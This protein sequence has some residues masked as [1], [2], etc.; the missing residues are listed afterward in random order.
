MPLTLN[1]DIEEQLQAI[2]RWEPQV[3]ALI[4][5]DEHAA[6]RRAAEAGAGPLSGWSVAVK[7]IIDWKGTPT[8]C[9]AD[10]M[11]DE[12]ARTSAAIIV[13]LEQLGAFVMSKAVTTVFAFF[14]PGPTRNPWNLE[15][16][17]GG[18][19]S[20]P[21]AAVACGMVRLALGSQTVGSINRPASFCG[22]VGFKPTYGRIPMGGVF[23]IAPA[24]DTLGWFTA[25]VGDAQAAFAALTGEEAAPTPRSLRIGVVED[26]LCETADV[27]MLAAVRA[28]A[29]RLRRAGYDV[30]AV[31]LPPSAA[32]I[33]EAHWT[34][35]A[36][37]CARSHDSLFARHADRYTPKLRDLILRGQQIDDAQ[38]SA[39]ES[40]RLGAADDL[41]RLFDDH[42]VL[43]TP[44]APGPAPHGIAATGDP[45]MNLVWTYTGL[46]SLTLAAELSEN[47]LPLGMQFVAPRMVDDM[48][49]A[50]G[51]VLERDLG[52]NARP[53]LPE[54]M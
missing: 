50:A 21:A 49:L 9:G 41:E 7:D 37:Q 52:F 8:R 19:S 29:D 11:P 38:I 46:P 14:D 48:L 39:L 35:V 45:R 22:V 3:H 15:H 32:E 53:Q 2:G 1:N 18:S 10:F 43:L 6:R 24:V 42:D 5:F 13:R 33:Y 51:G 54:C 26:M 17:P 31:R 47:G 40:Q 20:G 34:L 12:P 4:D 30:Q 44:S 25:N 23:P 28:C 16:T 36:A 27:A